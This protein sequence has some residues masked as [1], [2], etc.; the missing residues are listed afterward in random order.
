LVSTKVK[1]QLLHETA[2]I[3]VHLVDVLEE[4]SPADDLPS[5]FVGF[6]RESRLKFRSNFTFALRLLLTF[7]GHLKIKRA[8]HTVTLTLGSRAAHT[9]A[10]HDRQAV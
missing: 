7:V 3:L 10:T 8:Q 2:H 6:D 4:L 9:V 1:V 5:S